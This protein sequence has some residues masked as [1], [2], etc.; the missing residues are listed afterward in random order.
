MDGDSSYGILLNGQGTA[1]V[2]IGRRTTNTDAITLRN[3]NINGLY[4]Q[5]NEGFWA[6]ANARIV[7]GFFFETIN[8]NYNSK[9]G[10]YVGNAYS[11]ILFASSKY[12]QSDFCPLGSLFYLEALHDWVFNDQS[13]YD[14]TT[15]QYRCGSDIQSHSTKG[16]K[17]YITF[18][19]YVDKIYI[20]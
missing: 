13:I 14:L 12:F 8:W 3:V 1:V 7:H 15:L 10:L 5:P 16:M 2:N 9:N 6:E 17:I 20:L 11:D 18:L 4:V 19:K